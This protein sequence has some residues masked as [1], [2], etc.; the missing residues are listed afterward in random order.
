MTFEIEPAQYTGKAM[1]VKNIITSE[2]CKECGECCKNYP[3]VELSQQDILELEKVTGLPFDDFTNPKGGP[4]EGYFLT[5][6]ENGDCVFLNENNGNY[7][8]SVYDAR[9]AVCRNY[10]AKQS[11]HDFCNSN[12]KKSTP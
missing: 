10:P 9:S 3:F 1:T 12:R 11:Q 5:F 2:I 7:C 4:G 8:C 6:K